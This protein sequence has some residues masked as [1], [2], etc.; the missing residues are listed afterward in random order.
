V[1]AFVSLNV[2]RNFQNCQ[3][4]RETESVERKSG[5]GRASTRISETVER[6]REII[7]GVS[8]LYRT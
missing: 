8:K 3:I 7:Q 4:F 6:V 1:R 5:N 2:W